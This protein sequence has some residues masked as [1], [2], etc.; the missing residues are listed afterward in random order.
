MVGQKNFAPDQTVVLRTASKRRCSGSGFGGK[1]VAMRVGSAISILLSAVL[2]GGVSRAAQG[3]DFCINLPKKSRM[4]P[5]QE[6]NRD[7]VKEA[8]RGHLQKAKERFVKAYLLDPDDPFTLNNLGYVAEL[9]GDV[10]RALRYYQ[11][12]GNT[13]TEAVID[14]ATSDGLK[15]QPV[16]A[17]F[18][19]SQVSAYQ[20]N[21]ANFRAMALIQKGRV[22]EAELVLK[23][24]LQSDPKNPFLLD[25][26]GYVMESEGDLQAALK[27]YTEAAEVHSDERVL[28]TPVKK[29]RGKSV[30]EVA[31]RSASAVKEAL[32]K[33]E[34]TE[35]RVTRLN[36]QGVSAL[37]HANAADAQK[38][39]NN[40]YQLDPENAFTLNNLGYLVELNGDRETAEMYYDAARS[41][42]QAN[43]RVTYAT[44][45]DAEGRKLGS[46]A[47]TNQ[48]DVNA[49]L[50]AVQQKK[51]QL[52]RPIQ[53]MVRNGG[54]AT[55]PIEELKQQAPLRVPPPPLPA[56]KLPDRDSAPP[57]AQPISPQS[58]PSIQP[59]A[60]GPTNPLPVQPASPPANH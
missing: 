13:N 38:Y 40:A 37:N 14:V 47:E 34:D 53:L 58:E 15:G 50:K 33:G 45:A 55:P 39:F 29:W 5:V 11:L 52:K 60:P 22:F 26:M 1:N 4:T 36:L 35:T 21:R 8:R 43:E 19:S 56:P 31:A 54:A 3:G 57:N 25:T 51:R 32:A 48:G 7:G 17:A 42:E 28:L 9:E 41:A 24:A 6:L 46:L 2:L 44:R 30:S 27:Y 12:A 16:V 18:Q 49:T 10:D 59:L 23:R 20:A